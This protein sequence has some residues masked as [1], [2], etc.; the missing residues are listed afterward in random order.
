MARLFAPA[1]ATLKDSFDEWKPKTAV[2]RDV[3]RKLAPI[4]RLQGFEAERA[5]D[6]DADAAS[7]RSAGSP[8]PKMRVSKL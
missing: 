5:D 7:M 8:D 3:K 6:A 2:L 1:L 4:R